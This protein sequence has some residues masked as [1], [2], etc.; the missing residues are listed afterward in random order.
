M[1]DTFF[2]VFNSRMLMYAQCASIGAEGEDSVVWVA[3]VRLADQFLG[4][5]PEA[6]RANETLDNAK[7][8]TMSIAGLSQTPVYQKI[9]A[10]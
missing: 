3:A 8:I 6:D 1:Q 9:L 7:A 2:D 10:T 5:R 4:D